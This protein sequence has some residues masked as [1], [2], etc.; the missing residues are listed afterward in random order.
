PALGSGPA[1]AA[2]HP[3]RDPRPARQPMGP[4][5]H[6][7][8][9]RAPIPAVVLPRALG[10]VRAE[11]APPDAVLDVHPGSARGAAGRTAGLSHTALD[12]GVPPVLRD[13]ALLPDD[14]RPAGRTRPDQPGP[15]V[16]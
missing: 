2:D 16:Q 10:S 7:R 8:R 11:V 12:P 15:E 3:A 9:L 5:G 4:L 14:P 1:M 13:P 6:P